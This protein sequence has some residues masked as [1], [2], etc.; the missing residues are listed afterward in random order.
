MMLRY[1]AWDKEDLISDIIELEVRRRK[2]GRQVKYQADIVDEFIKKTRELGGKITI[3]F[4]KRRDGSP[5][6]T[7]NEVDR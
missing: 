7:H 2:D 1:V 6:E 5:A 4:P 3:E